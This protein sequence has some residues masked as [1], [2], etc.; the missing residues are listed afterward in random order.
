[1]PPIALPPS[2]L[3]DRYHMQLCYKQHQHAI[4]NEGLFRIMTNWTELETPETLNSGLVAPHISEIV[5]QTSQFEMMKRWYTT[6]LGVAPFFVKTP[7]TGFKPV[8]SY[9]GKLPAVS[10]CFIRVSFQFPYS[11][12]LALFEVPDLEGQSVRHS[13]LHHMQFR[14]E[15]LSQQFE[16]YERLRSVGIVPVR[17]CNHGPGTSFYYADPDSNVVELSSPNFKTEEDYLAFFQTPGYQ[18]NPAGLDVD[19]D[20]YVGRFRDGVPQEE[21]VRIG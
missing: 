1:M 10:I 14:L 17:A 11:Q 12:V 8:G 19:A 4:R 13:G 2:R 20:E 3:D 9:K 15:G 7:A 21:L 16:R 5:L 18:K 6:F